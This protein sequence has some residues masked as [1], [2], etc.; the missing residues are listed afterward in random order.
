MRKEMYALLDTKEITTLL[1]ANRIKYNKKFERLNRLSYSYECKELVP[2]ILYSI[3][4]LIYQGINKSFK[5]NIKDQILELVDISI[6]L[7]EKESTKKISDYKRRVEEIM[8]KNR[9]IEKENN[10]KE[11]V[12]EYIERTVEG[13]EIFKYSSTGPVAMHAIENAI[14]LLGQMKEE[15]ENVYDFSTEKAS[16][17]AYNVIAQIRKFRNNAMINNFSDIVNE[18]LEK[19][20]ELIKDWSELKD[21]VSLFNPA[22]SK[23]NMVS[24]VPSA[25]D[26]LCRVNKH[27][28]QLSAF[29]E[30]VQF[31]AKSSETE[32][33]QAAEYQRKIDELADKIEKLEEEIEE[34]ADKVANAEMDVDYASQRYDQLE[35]QIVGLEELMQTYNDA[36]IN[37]EAN[38]N[39][40]EVPLLNLTILADKIQMYKTRPI[41]YAALIETL[42]FGAI[43]QALDGVG[44]VDNGSIL[45]IQKALTQME[46]M[47]NLESQG[48]ESIKSV[49]TGAIRKQNESHVNRTRPVSD[50]TEEEKRKEFEEKMRNRKVRSS[51]LPG[52]GTKVQE[53]QETK[54]ADER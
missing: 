40:R 19:G 22:A 30:K 32:I 48:F 9:K 14:V 33:K 23:K 16:I 31:H 43:N 28:N 36:K 12:L 52:H 53:K 54:I 2:S 37:I 25:F 46:T 29:I 8:A 34:N 13:M 18:D 47:R 26:S 50:K 5:K 49:I 51:K 35:D 42:D 38:I 45:S 39:S 24:Y 1:K 15:L 21:A 10:M 4:L 41:I 27:D 6:E 3:D 44:K 7:S 17:Y 11:V 20:K